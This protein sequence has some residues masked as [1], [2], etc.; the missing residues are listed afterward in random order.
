MGRQY[1]IRPYADLP[2]PFQYLGDQG[3]KYVFRDARASVYIKETFEVRFEP[4][5]STPSNMKVS[6][7]LL[8]YR[9]K[10]PIDYP[11]QGNPYSRAV[12]DS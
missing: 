10:R 6:Q 1:R 11:A 4:V 12:C 5:S 7:Y 2:A 8:S 9:G 3:D